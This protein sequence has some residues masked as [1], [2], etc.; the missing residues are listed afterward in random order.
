MPDITGAAAPLLQVE[1]LR[2]HFP[3]ESRN[4]DGTRK[5]VRAIDGV[6]FTMQRGEVLGLVGESGSGKST[7]GRVVLRLHEPTDGRVLFDGIDLATLGRTALRRARRRMQMVFQDPYSSLNPNMRVQEMLEEALIVHRLE[8]DAAARRAQVATL[9]DMVGMN[10]GFAARFPHELSGGQ[11]QRVAIARALAVR[12]EFIVADEAVSALDVSNQ[13]QVLNV[14]VELRRRL[15]LTV[16]FISHNLAVVQN[17]ADRVAVL[18]LGRMMEIAP[19]AALFATPRHPYTA[20]LL[21]AIPIPDPDARR[22]RV[23]ITGEIPSAAN[24]PSG[25]VFRTRCPMAMDACATDVP[26]LKDLGDGH[27][28]ACLRV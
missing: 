8:P 9:L 17:V 24:P 16:L 7:I 5:V 13:A 2:K 26:P 28:A 10:A 15:G 1:G 23:A 21:S 12:P 11:R 18:Y 14:M 4:P 27:L 22:T 20:A 19:A 6:S 25:C 3:T